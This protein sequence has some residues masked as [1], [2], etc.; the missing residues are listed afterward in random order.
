M[1][2]EMIR[3]HRVWNE[4]GQTQNSARDGDPHYGTIAPPTGSRQ[5]DKGEDHCRKKQQSP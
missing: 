5:R 4:R 2:E 3:K 1:I